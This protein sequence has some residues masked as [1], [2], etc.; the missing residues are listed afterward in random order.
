M[1]SNEGSIVLDPCAGSGTTGRSCILTNR[2]Y[3]LFDINKEG[4]LLFEQSIKNLNY[5]VEDD[6]NPLLNAMN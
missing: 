6:N 3:I 2:T 1:F 4:K 5:E